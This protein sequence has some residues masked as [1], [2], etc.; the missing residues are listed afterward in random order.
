MTGKGNA[1]FE[2]LLG[3]YDWQIPGELIAQKP[4]SPR[5]SARLLVGWKNR[6]ESAED[7]FLN[8]DKYLPFGAV[9]VFNN[10]KVIPARLTLQK[11]TGGQVRVLYLDHDKNMIRVLADRPVVPGMKLIIPHHPVFSFVVF[12]KSGKYVFLKPSFAIAKFPALLKQF[13]SMPIP[14]Y[15]KSHTMTESELRKQYQTVFAKRNGSVAAPTASLHFTKRLLAK[16]ARKH[17]QLCYVT[18]HVNLGTF[19]PLVPEQVRHGKLHQEYYEIDHKTARILHQAKKEGRPIIA[20][21]TTVVRTLESAAGKDRQ[22]KRLSG[23]TDLFIREGYRFKFIDGMITNFHVPKSSLLM[24]VAAFI[25]KE[26]LR[27]LYKKAIAER[28]KFFS[29]GDGMLLLPNK[30][31]YSGE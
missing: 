2:K 8:L 25:G 26:K 6:P 28:F 7:T 29:F 5:D 17:F 13:G 10:T 20:V 11:E 1:S 31:A 18:L 19:S 24:L 30:R 12:Q 14:P 21:G 4:A 3:Q 15:I 22:I 16:L 23:A 27:G 9:L